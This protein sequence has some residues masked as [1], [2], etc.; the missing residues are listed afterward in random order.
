MAVFN[1]KIRPLAMWRKQKSRKDAATGCVVIFWPE[2]GAVVSHVEMIP[3]QRATLF[4]FETMYL[5]I[6]A[7]IDLFRATSMCDGVSVCVHVI[8]LD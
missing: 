1:V 2:G 3:A 7:N 5:V 8:A 4:Q 6:S